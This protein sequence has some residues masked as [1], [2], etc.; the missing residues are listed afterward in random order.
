MTQSARPRAARVVAQS[1][2]SFDELA[3]HHPVDEVIYVAGALPREHFPV[4]RVREFLAAN[5]P[6]S[7]SVQWSYWAKLVCLCDYFAFGPQT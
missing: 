4:P 1:G 2:Y 5:I 6:D 7:A 3:A